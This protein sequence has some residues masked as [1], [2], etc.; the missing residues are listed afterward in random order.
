MDK[1]KRI[2]TFRK[3]IIISILP[4]QLIKT[5]FNCLNF[6]SLLLS[7]ILSLNNSG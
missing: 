2:N 7:F 4:K 1:D 5:G 3:T 6:I